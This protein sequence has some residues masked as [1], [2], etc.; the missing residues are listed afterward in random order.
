MAADPRWLEHCA[1]IRASLLELRSL[2]RENREPRNW[3]DEYVEANELELALHVVCDFLA[4]QA[5][6]S[7]GEKELNSIRALHEKM[8]IV[9]DCCARLQGSARHAKA[10]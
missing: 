7:I 1:N 10:L 8:V 6:Q 5:P 4:E 9:D 2:F 3:F